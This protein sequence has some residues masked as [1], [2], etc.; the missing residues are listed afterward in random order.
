[1]IDKNKSNNNMEILNKLDFVQI[2]SIGISG[3]G[4]L[5]ILLAFLLIYREQNRP[6]EPRKG[7]ISTIRYFMALNFLSVVVVGFFGLPLI[8]KNEKL[9]DENA[10]TKTMLTVRANELQVVQNANDFDQLIDT[11][12]TSSLST[13]Q[14]AKADAYVQSL[15]SLVGNYSTTDSVKADSLNKFKNINVMHFILFCLAVAIKYFE[16]ICLFFKISAYYSLVLT[17]LV[18]L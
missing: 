4:F 5:L 12:K 6:Q 14:I 17:N 7:I 11:A 15:D 10:L 1:M 16:C 18:S 13:E 8:S 3:F 2:L 9:K